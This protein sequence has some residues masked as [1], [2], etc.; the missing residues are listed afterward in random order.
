MV[1]QFLL[2]I[3]HLRTSCKIVGVKELMFW[4]LELPFMGIWGPRMGGEE[5]HSRG[6]SAQRKKG[7]ATGRTPA[8]FPL[9]VCH[10]EEHVLPLQSSNMR[11]CIVDTLVSPI[12]FDFAPQIVAVVFLLLLLWFFLLDACVISLPPLLERTAR[13]VPCLVSHRAGAGCAALSV[14]RVISFSTLS[15]SSPG[16]VPLS[17]AQTERFLHDR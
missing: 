1:L 17:R 4:F 7:G 14:G 5:R 9:L 13:I 8:F 12:L 15:L 6:P 16:S 11:S 3:F 10:E 2:L